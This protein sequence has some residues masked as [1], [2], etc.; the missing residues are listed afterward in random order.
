MTRCL[1]GWRRS[2]GDLIL[3]EKLGGWML[4]KIPLSS[5]MGIRGMQD[6]L[7][8]ADVKIKEADS[9]IDNTVNL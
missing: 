3:P 4:A 5:H 2:E 1:E 8:H 7:L 9:K 6:L